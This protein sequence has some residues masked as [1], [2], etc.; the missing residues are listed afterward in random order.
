MVDYTKIKELIFRLFREKY[1][2]NFNHYYAE[3]GKIKICWSTSVRYT[4]N[5][6]PFSERDNLD[7][8]P[9][10]SIYFPGFVDY[11]AIPLTNKEFLELQLILEEVY[12]NWVQWRAD[13]IEKTLTNLV[14]PTNFDQAQEQVLND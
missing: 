6:Q 2:N 3:Y 5:L 1:P 11:V 8:G 14:S 7:E 9:A 4:E 13:D 12:P 10:I